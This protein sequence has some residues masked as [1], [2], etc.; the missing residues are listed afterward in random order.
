MSDWR[1]LT[2]PAPTRLPEARPAALY[3]LGL[4][5]AVVSVVTGS[6]VFSYF[7]L[8]ANAEDWPHGGAPPPGVGSY[9]LSVLLSA[10]AAAAATYAHRDAV[11]HDDHRR[12]AMALAACA[13]AA[14]GSLVV[15]GLHLADLPFAVDDHA[16]GA[17]VTTLVGTVVLVFAGGTIGALVVMA[18]VLLGHA[19]TGTADARRIVRA[20]WISAVVL[21][22]VVF[23]VLLGGAR[24]L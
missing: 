6:L 20:Y 24:M 2:P 15:L 3:G 23:A 7:H 12:S 5:Y 22:V 9:A 13:T 10:L 19:E 11:R 8:A 14:V 4:L 16:Y 18:W 21:A 1:T 17:I